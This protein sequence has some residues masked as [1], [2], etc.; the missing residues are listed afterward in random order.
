MALMPTRTP[1]TN[2]VFPHLAAPRQL[3]YE[4]RRLTCLVA[5]KREIRKDCDSDSLEL[6]H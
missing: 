1:L 3:Y 5:G 6:L 4:Y 2:A